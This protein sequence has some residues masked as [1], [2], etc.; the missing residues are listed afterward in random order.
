[1]PTLSEQQAIQ[2]ERNLRAVINSFQAGIIATAKSGEMFSK[3]AADRIKYAPQLYEGI[4]SALNSSGYNGIVQDLIARDAELIKEIRSLRTAKGLPTAFTNTSKETLAA[5]QR[6]E[7]SQFQSIG[8]GF[9]NSLHQQLMSLAIGGIGEREFIANISAKLDSG[10][11]RYATTYA[12]TSRAKF[13]QQVEDEAAKSY[14]GELYWEYVGAIDDRNRDAC[15]EGLEYNNG[16]GMFTD[17]ER[18]EFEARTADERLWN[19]RHTFVQI[20]KE[21][22]ED[23]KGGR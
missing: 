23:N 10:F 1:M 12:E 6:L 7:L 14:D 15:I 9:A 22:Y 21:T 3:N 17:A 2:F 20:T 8:E 11:K 5:F 18:D 13:I 19:C 16:T 4:I